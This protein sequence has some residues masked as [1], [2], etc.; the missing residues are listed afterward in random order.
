[1]KILVTG[2]TGYLGH[3]VHAY[4][5]AKH[6]VFGASHD[7]VTQGDNYSCDLRDKNQVEAL[8]RAVRADVVIHTAGIKDIQFCEKNKA[9]A[10]AV[11]SLA[12]ENI[13][14][15]FGKSSRILYIS[16]D[17]VFGGEAGNYS[18][19]SL[20]APKTVYGESKLSGERVGV[21]EAADNFFTVRTAAV[22]NDTAKF[23]SYLNTSLTKSVPV[24]C[25]ID[26]F[27]SPTYYQDLLQSLNALLD[28][29]YPSRV[30]HVSGSRMSRFEFA[31]LAAAVQGYSADL[32]LPSA[33]PE[34]ECYLFP[35][36]SLNSQATQAMLNLRRTPHEAALKCIF[37]GKVKA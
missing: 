27:Y 24:S 22:Y 17:Y 37:S 3:M 34:S 14:K 30:F 5:S 31:K 6:Q 20:P 1:M 35:D 7:C 23:L 16:T 25:Y 2:F 10:F 28:G 19:T 4:F 29:D 18:E 26:V 36:L 9:E 11:N 13:A 12:T 8:L 32:V 21:T 15:A 33:R